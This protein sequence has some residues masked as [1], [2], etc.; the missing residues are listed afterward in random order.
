MPETNAESNAR[1]L[2]NRWKAV[3]GMVEVQIGNQADFNAYLKETGA[4]SL[5]DGTL[6]VSVKNGFVKAWI[7]QRVMPSLRRFAAQV[8]KQDINIELKTLEFATS[9]VLLREGLAGNH[10]EWA[11]ASR[12]RHHDAMAR[13][14][15]R[16]FPTV[17]GC[18]F[19]R[20]ESSES[21][22]VA[23]NATKSVVENPG[24]EFN[25]LTIASDTGQGKTHLLNA[26][27]SAMRAKKMNVICLTGE[28][29]VDGFVKATR[30]G[31]VVAMRDRF[32]GVDA[33]LVDGIEKLIGKDGTRTFFLSTIDHLISSGKQLVF[34]FNTAYPMQELGE[35][36]TS[37]L[38][39]GLE[40]SINPPDVELQK[41]VL[42]RYA[43]ERNLPEMEDDAFGYLANIVVRNVREIIGGIARV[44]AYH[45]IAYQP[46]SVAVPTI[47][48]ELV[49]DATRDRL[50][51]P[52]PLMLT[53]DDVFKAVAE[54]FDVEVDALRR[55]GRGNQ[56]LSNARDLTAHM[57]REK[58]GLSSTETG[59]LLGGRPHSTILA[60]LSRY[61]ERRETEH[62][63]IE[64]ER[65]VERL[66]R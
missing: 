48:R 1:E 59:V 47:T 50:S 43:S 13:E 41:S 2:Q 3:L 64:A 57:L 18:T 12:G 7:R 14:N 56:S 39:A 61:S 63:L 52:Q 34:T 38:A 15:A 60:A 42:R 5:E 25:P 66:L 53:P 9:D 54:V 17:N 27:A 22:L 36:I 26:A 46:E 35:E 44:N 19:D 8:F 24:D 32:R 51:A 29:F 21:N 49:V 30:K 31:N 20:F 16:Y 55:S 65:Q 11:A 37:R 45:S 33:L 4:T 28:E 40:I 23:L 6:T 10:E 58:C 62:Q